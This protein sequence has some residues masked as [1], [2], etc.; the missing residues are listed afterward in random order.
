[1]NLLYGWKIT[2]KMS[3]FNIKIDFK[4]SR[5]SFI[6]DKNTKKKYLDFL[7]MYSSLPLG[8][9]HKIFNSCKFKKEIKESSSVKLVNCEIDSDEYQDF[10]KEFKRFTSCNLYKNYFF[11]CTG[12]LANEAAIKTAMWHKGTKK[13]GYVLSIKNSF[14]GINSFGNII[15]T[16]FHQI[17]NRQGNVFGEDQWR[18]ADNLEEA[19]D[20]VSSKHRNLQGVIIEPIQSTYGDKYLN[21][22]KLKKLRKVCDEFDI[23]LIF[24][25][26]QT[27][28]GASGTKWLFEKIGIEPDIVVFGKKSQVSG[29]M[30]KEKFSKVFEIPKRLSVTF[31]GDLIDMIR[32]KYIIQAIEKYNLLQNA[33][34]MGKKIVDE[35]KKIKGLKNVRGT[36]LLIAFD[37]E[38]TKERDLF[39]KNARSLGLLCNPTTLRTIRIRPNLAVTE[40]EVNVFLEIVKKNLNFIKKSSL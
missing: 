20:I 12:S 34:D 19:I 32:C 21:K 17:K 7:G 31:D 35:L 3:L 27:G 5:G 16:R 25:E 40:K 8:Y 4:K 11:T 26:V 22:L 6:F 9:N 29:I 24:D 10:F 38:S 23:P 18:Q 37:L 30:V 15:T 1:M 39:Y 13:D 33:E 28:F 14:H 36:G 2:L